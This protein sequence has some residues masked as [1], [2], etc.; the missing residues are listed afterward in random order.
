MNAQIKPVGE[1]RYFGYSLLLL[2]SL[3]LSSVLFSQEEKNKLTE[4]ILHKDSLFW[5]AY[6]NCNVKTFTDFFTTDI[7]F[8]HDKGGITLG[9]TALDESLKKNICGSPDHKIRREAVPGTINVFPMKNGDSLYGAAISGEHLFY[10]SDNGKPE[11]LTGHARFMN[12]WLLKNGEWKMARI[13]S[14]DHNPVTYVNKRKEIALSENELTQ[15]TGNYKSANFGNMSVVIENKNVILQTSN[16]NFVLY[17]E[18]KNVFFSKERDLTFEF[19]KK[20]NKI[21]KMIV[22]ENGN[23]V[24]EVAFINK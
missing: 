17:P 2:L 9:A 16:E 22:R 14:Y 13:L 10:I 3:L 11:I 8:Y 1:A 15:F 7:E 4:T 6:N 21:E 24:E 23:I 20:D 19:V 12:L 18:T 5:N